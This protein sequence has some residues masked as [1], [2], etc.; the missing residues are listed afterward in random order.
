MPLGVGGRRY[1][2]TNPCA[3]IISFESDN[4]I[5]PLWQEGDVTARGISVVHM[6]EGVGSSPVLSIPF[7]IVL[8]QENKVVPVKL[9]VYYMSVDREKWWRRL[10]EL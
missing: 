4:D 5:P 9:L 2:E 6:V 3:R 10:G 7:C 8:G 1:Y